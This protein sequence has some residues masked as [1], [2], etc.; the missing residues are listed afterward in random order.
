MKQRIPVPLIP[1]HARFKSGA[2]RRW[3]K[4]DEIIYN[5]T[6]GSC[7]KIS[8]S[9]GAWYDPAELELEHRGYEER[10]SDNNSRTC[11]AQVQP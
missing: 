2:D 1:T 3:Y 9:C 11:A 4:I 7:I 8:L 6:I 10:H 5:S